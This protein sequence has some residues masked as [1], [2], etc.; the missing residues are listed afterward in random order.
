MAWTFTLCLHNE[1]TK[2]CDVSYTI[3]ATVQ[4][5]SKTPLPQLNPQF[6]QQSRTTPSPPLPNPPH[7]PPAPPQTSGSSSN[8]NRKNPLHPPPT[9]PRATPR[10]REIFPTPRS[11]S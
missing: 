4:Q 6:N 8:T 2:R 5:Y 7:Q 11:R 9:P 10:A 1:A 3:A